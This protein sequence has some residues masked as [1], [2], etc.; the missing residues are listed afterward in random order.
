MRFLQM[1]HLGNKDLIF[2]NTNKTSCGPKRC[3]QR[4]V[5]LSDA[6]SRLHACS[7]G[8][9]QDAFGITA[10]VGGGDAGGAE[11]V[12]IV[13]NAALGVREPEPVGQ[14]RSVRLAGS[15]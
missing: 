3:L 15:D 9:R 11:V 5:Y 6:F 1:S 13:R 2:P 7:A 10:V 4:C 14:Q 8:G 12:L